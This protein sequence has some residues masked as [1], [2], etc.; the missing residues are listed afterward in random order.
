MFPQSPRATRFAIATFCFTHFATADDLADYR[1]VHT[2]ATTT[3]Q[4]SSA[5]AV[6]AVGYLGVQLALNK[7]KQ[8]IVAGI[9]ENSRAAQAGLRKDDV[10]ISADGRTFPDI[11]GFR[12]WLRAHAP[13]ETVALNLW[14]GGVAFR[15]TATL[16]SASHPLKPSEERGYVG[17]SY[18]EPNDRGAVVTNVTP[19]S[20]AAAAGIKAGDILAKVG[21]TPMSSFSTLTDV[22]TEKSPGDNLP[23][24][25]LHGEEERQ[26]TIKLGAS[27]NGPNSL[28]SV[29]P[30]IWKRDTYRLAVVGVEF[31]DVKMNP[32]ITAEAWNEA[33]FSAGTYANKTSPT[34]QK[35]YGSFGD[36]YREVS[37]GKLAVSGKVFA[38]VA[39]AKKREEFAT[40]QREQDQT[41]FYNEIVD[42]LIEREGKDALKDFDGLIFIYAGDRYPKVNRGALF[43]PHRGSFMR[44]GKR[45]SYYICPEGGATMTSISVFCHEFGHMLGLPDLYARPENPGSEGLGI[46]CLMSNERGAGKPQHMS[47]WCKEQLGWLKPAVIDPAVPQKLVLGPVEGSTDECFKVPI[48][49]DGAEYLLLENRRRTGFDTSLPAEGL[50]IWRVVGRRPILE[51]SHGVEGPVGPRVFL[52]SVPYPSKSNNAFTPFTTPS[53]R[54]QLGGGRSVFLTNIRQLADGR[55]TFEIGYEYQ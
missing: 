30:S 36:F 22:L 23:L 11:A 44:A 28:A 31:S 48:R 52:G 12:D 41:A 27:T 24:T 17:I 43:W 33:L 34:G 53:S 38:P 14:R 2:A 18:G 8:I 13:G 54:G 50:L 16:D 15:I 46:W 25:L 42:R 21:E 47:A 7:E 51:E 20:P 39:V 26:I 5:A 19:K 32:K 55:V 3:I 1:T 40:T 35:V 45:Q 29:L 4:P 10:I 9:D 49:P 37:C 6:G